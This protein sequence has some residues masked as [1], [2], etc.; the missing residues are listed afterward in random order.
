MNKLLW[1]DD[2]GDTREE[3]ARTLAVELSLECVYK[4]PG[5][6]Q[7]VL[8]GGMRG[9]DAIFVDH[10]LTHND[11]D[12]NVGSNKGASLCSELRVCCPD[13][14]IFGISAAR[15]DQ[16]S[17]T[18]RSEYDLFATAEKYGELRAN[19]EI[20]S[21]VNGFAQLRSLIRPDIIYEGEDFINAVLDQFGAHREDL[22]VMKKIL[23]SC[24]RSR[25]SF[26]IHRAFQWVSTKFM[27]KDGILI[28]S[29][30]IAAM[31]GLK[32]EAFMEKIKSK[33]VDCCY[34][35]VFSFGDN[36]FWRSKVL[37]KLA[38]L[39]HNDGS[40]PLS[41]YCEKLDGVLSDECAT[42]AKCGK[43][44]TEVLAYEDET[45]S[46]NK[47]PAHYDCVIEIEKGQS[48]FFDA[49]YLLEESD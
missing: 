13:V 34:K 21:A 15:D 43:K 38:N 10:Y 20:K 26:N 45:P 22:S 14:P 16:L 25:E 4:S 33:L 42:C 36:V 27:R 8:N 24:L 46:A 35:G 41:H 44:Y 39:T 49:D 1:I 3:L 9:Y 37:A 5:E 40:T 48:L 29:K 23:P 32:D 30:S 18:E 47:Y 6:V 2:G 31:I 19:G 28:H 7:Q 11:G 17:L 12:R